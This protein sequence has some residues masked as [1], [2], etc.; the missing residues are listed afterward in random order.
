MG[1]AVGEPGIQHMNEWLTA[2]EAAEYLK[3]SHR[4]IVKWARS[5]RIPA[6]RLGG[7]RHTWRFLRSELD[8][9]LTASSGVSAEREAA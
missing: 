7:G 3:V 2:S 9:M 4:S 1:A 5:G 8:A 6:H